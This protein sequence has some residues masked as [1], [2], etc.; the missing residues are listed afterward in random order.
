[1]KETKAK[2]RCICRKGEHEHEHVTATLLRVAFVYAHER[3]SHADRRF[4]DRSDVRAD[5][6]RYGGEG[7]QYCEVQVRQV[8]HRE[9]S[10]ELLL[11]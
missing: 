10:Q 3:T 9:V 2:S 5:P 8:R 1:M 7:E 4:Q 11:R 6:R